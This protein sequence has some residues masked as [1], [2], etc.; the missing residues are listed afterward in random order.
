MYLILLL[1]I[2]LRTVSDIS[3]KLGMLRLKFPDIKSFFPNFL[4]M[5]ANPFIWLGGIIAITNIAA[6]SM[7]LVK[8]DL[9]FAYPFTSISFVLIILSGKLFFK[10]R[11]D[12]MK[13]LGISS[14]IIGGI[15][16]VLGAI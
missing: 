16:L 9:N 10:E 11:L 1:T 5:M 14:I 13:I 2:L 3:F 15:I 8:F 12:K 6:W 4:K 7:S